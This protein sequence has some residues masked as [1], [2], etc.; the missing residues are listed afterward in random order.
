MNEVQFRE[1]WGQFKGALKQQWEQ[2]TDAD[3]LQ[4]DGDRNKFNTAIQ[5]RYGERMGDVTK[6]VDR[7]YAKW[8][9]WY[10]GYEEVT[11]TS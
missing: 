4:I 1:S 6:W 9:G 8:S 10:E 11:L 7:R 3:I 2:L 5:S